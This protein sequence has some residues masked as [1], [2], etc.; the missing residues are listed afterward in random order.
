MKPKVC[1]NA[2]AK[3]HH[4]SI[5]S[6]HRCCAER[7]LINKYEHMAHVKGVPKHKKVHWVRK[8]MGAKIVIWRR[9]RTGE[10][11][12]SFPCLLCRQV[13]N[14]YDMNIECNMWDG[15]IYKSRILDSCIESTFTTSQK[16]IFK[17][18]APSKSS[19]QM[20]QMSLPKRASINKG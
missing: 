9:L 8:Q 2:A 5:Q 18:D 10:L 1:V 4:I 16:R 7:L 6:T 19:L 14:K 12:C 3:N 13:L 17:K 15:S 20:G 11:S